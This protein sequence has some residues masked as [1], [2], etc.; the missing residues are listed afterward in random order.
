LPVNPGAAK[1]P[2]DLAPDA[3]WQGQGAKYFV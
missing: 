2:L 3:E 1:K